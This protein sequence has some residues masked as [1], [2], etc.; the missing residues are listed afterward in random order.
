[1][2]SCFYP[3]GDKRDKSGRPRFQDHGKVKNF[4]AILNVKTDRNGQPDQREKLHHLD[5]EPAGLGKQH[6]NLNRSRSSVD[7]S[8]LGPL[9]SFA[10]HIQS[11]SQRFPSS[12]I[13]VSH[14]RRESEITED[15]PDGGGAGGGGGGGLV[16]DE[17][18]RSKR[19][20]QAKSFRK[21]VSRRSADDL[22]MAAA[23]VDH[24]TA[25][26][27]DKQAQFNLAGSFRKLVS[28][29]SADD[30][31][32]I[33][34]A[35]QDDKQHYVLKSGSGSRGNSYRFGDVDEKNLAL[36]LAP[37]GVNNM[38]EIVE[39]DRLQPQGTSKPPWNP[40]SNSESTEGTGGPKDQSEDHVSDTVLEP[41]QQQQEF[42]GF[43]ENPSG[44]VDNP[45]SDF[46]IQTDPVFQQNHHH[47]ARSGLFNDNGAPIT[48]LREMAVN[49]DVM[50]MPLEPKSEWERVLERTL[51]QMN[52]SSS[53]ALTLQGVEEDETE[54]AASDKFRSEGEDHKDDH[55]EEVVE[56]VAPKLSQDSQE[57][58]PDNW[59]NT[60][61]RPVHHSNR[62]SVTEIEEEDADEEKADKR[63]LQWTT[64]SQRV[65]L[66]LGR[67]RPPG[68]GK[69]PVTEKV[70]SK[71]AEKLNE[72]FAQLAPTSHHPWAIWHKKPI[73]L[74]I[75][76][77]EVITQKEE[78]ND[79]KE[80][81]MESVP[82]SDHEQLSPLP[83]PFQ[84]DENHSGG[85]ATDSGRYDDDR[86]VVSVQ[87]TPNSHH[88]D[89]QTTPNAHYADDQTTSNSSKREIVAEAGPRLSSV[90]D[91]EAVARLWEQLD[92]VEGEEKHGPVAEGR[93]QPP[94]VAGSEKS[95]AAGKTQKVTAAA[96]SSSTRGRRRR[97]RFST[98]GGSEDF[99]VVDIS[100]S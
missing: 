29:R 56:N 76:T 47:K 92:M 83:T 49:D 87:T 27:D 99:S 61:S 23:A 81:I 51:A 11:V 1:M 72:N 58:E 89:E 18:N 26:P 25:A 28:R 34:A 55:D 46:S 98:C 41:Q 40:N 78:E 36:L 8:P 39:I 21:L 60:T 32:S 4:A 77:D 9:T 10:D 13:K 65:S 14:T 7:K 16:N 57:V 50:I 66:W 64:I 30:L 15:A 88:V 85:T 95:M 84:T 93:Q 12:I 31:S 2:A 96:V 71:T 100:V 82:N 42:P 73:P 70:E 94:D 79:E 20:F 86:G 43:L 33:A 45:E 90:D 53:T 74:V 62:N 24:A 69:N 68:Q 91:N 52:G 97:V 67:S 38:P 80:S 3:K 59:Q 35:V 37:V 48:E 6:N 75:N 19:R 22:S 54:T 5:S 44:L 17:S 63:D